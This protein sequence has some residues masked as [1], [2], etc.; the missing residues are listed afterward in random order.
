MGIQ[1]K[2]NLNSFN[3]YEFLKHQNA[4]SFNMPFFLADS[5][6]YKNAHV[7]FPFRTF[8][9]GLGLTYSGEGDTFQIGSTDYS[10][11]TACL[12][13]VGPGMVCQWMGNYTAE[14]DTVYFTEELFSDLQSNSFL[15]SL[16][17]FF[18]GGNHVI[19]LSEEQ[20]KKMS[21]LFGLLK[22]LKEDKSAIPGIVYSMLM[23]AN[24]FH[25]SPNGSPKNANASNKEKIAYEFRKLVAIHFPEHKDVNYYASQLHITP[26]YLSEILQVQLGKSAKTFIDEYVMMEAKSLLKQTSLTIQEICYWL[27]F[28]DASH[29]TKAFKKMTNLTPTYYRKN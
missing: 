18:H 16:T 8:A 17:F 26:K 12:T 11:G 14:H 23:L 24:S 22:E 29:F 3:L 9:Y 10:V 15:Q 6:T 2:F 4:H 7:N 21:A 28:E 1:K 5:S 25:S 13:T 20:V 19:K 27:G